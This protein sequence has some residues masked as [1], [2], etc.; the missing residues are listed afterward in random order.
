MI[1]AENGEIRKELDNIIWDIMI[2]KYEKF[3]HDRKYI[4]LDEQRNDIQKTSHGINYL[5]EELDEIKAL[6]E[7][8]GYVSEDIKKKLI[9]NFGTNEIG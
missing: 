3:E 8:V 4:K 9:K 2:K 5:I 7:E 1:R 6:F